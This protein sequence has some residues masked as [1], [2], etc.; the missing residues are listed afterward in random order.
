MKRLLT[1]LAMALLLAAGARAQAGDGPTDPKAKK[2][3]AEGMD[4]LKGHDRQA[5]LGSFKKAD[6]QDGGHCS[7][8][9]DQMIKL[10]LEIGDFKAAD[11]AAQEM[12]VA[13]KDPKS[14][15]I[16][17]E[18]RAT[19]LMREGAAKGKD[20]IFAEADKEYKAALAA[21]PNFPEAVFGDGKA[22]AYLKQDDAARV[23]FEDYISMTRQGAGARDSAAVRQRAQLYA[24]RPELARARMAPAFAITMLDGQRVSLDDLQGKVVLIDFWATWCGPCREA[25]PHLRQIAQKFQ[26]QPLVVLSVS[27]DDDE[28][29]WRDFVAKN[30]MTWL[31]YRDV[32]GDRSLSHLFSVNAIPHTFTID[33][34]GVL[35][36]EHVGDASIEGKLKKLCAR[37]RELE[38]APK[39]TAKL[40]Q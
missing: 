32:R 7:A 2:S 1:C 37:A 27:L 22:L 10:G 31:Q 11:E 15:A 21:Y 18:Q 28:A 40:G 8:C 38:E 5:A 9:R 3:Y 35:Q 4:W 14:S 33:A 39:T 12:I 29:K 20:E 16:A 25:L 26:G 30:N 19:V 23:K 6:K 36:D 34:D 13:A 24:D 17:H